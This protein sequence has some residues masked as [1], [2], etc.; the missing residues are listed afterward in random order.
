MDALTCTLQ[1]L[2]ACFSW[3]SLY[4]DGGLIWQDS[5]TPHL[6]WVTRSTSTPSGAIETV[7]ALEMIDEPLNPYG[8]L[9][10]GYELQFRNVTLALEATHTSS[11]ETNSDKGINAIGIKARWY[12]FKH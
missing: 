11:L 7:T 2:I 5:A 9:S 6:E 4:V 12:P 8:N 3:S 10:I 1:T